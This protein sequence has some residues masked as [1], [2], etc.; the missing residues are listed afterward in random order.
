MVSTRER[1]KRKSG[2]FNVPCLG[3]L[4]RR[5][6]GARSRRKETLVCVCLSVGGQDEGDFILRVHVALD[7]DA[8]LR[9][10]DE[11]PGA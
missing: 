4:D 6:E 8:E 5:P 1:R 7:L 11:F 10:Q 2:K 9:G 3:V